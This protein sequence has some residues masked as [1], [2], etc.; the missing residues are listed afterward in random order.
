MQTQQSWSWSPKV[1]PENPQAHTTLFLY[2]CQFVDMADTI[3]KLS[4]IKWLIHQWALL[5]LENP[6]KC[7]CNNHSSRE[8]SLVGQPAAT[9]ITSWALDIYWGGSFPCLF[10]FLMATRSQEKQGHKPHPTGSCD[11]F[12]FLCHA[13]AHQQR[14]QDQS[15]G[16][17][18]FPFSS[19]DSGSS[20]CWSLPGVPRSPSPLPSQQQKTLSLFRY[21][22]M[23]QGGFLC[24]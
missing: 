17:F 24:S 1:C 4:F 22:H 16:S 5:A 10:C 9:N 3:S 12:Q 15:I 8:Q 14:E 6:N 13:A 23:F 2:Q 20:T 7:F 18:V 19:S 21:L 11:F